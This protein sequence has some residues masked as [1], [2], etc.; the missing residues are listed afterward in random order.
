MRVL[1][2]T[3]LLLGSVL[4]RGLLDGL[5]AAGDQLRRHAA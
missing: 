2:P 5:E 1:F 3:A 4:T